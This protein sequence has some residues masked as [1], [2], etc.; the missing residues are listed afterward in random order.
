LGCAVGCFV[1]SVGIE[2]DADVLVG[3]ALLVVDQGLQVLVVGSG[4]GTG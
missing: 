4:G 2:S 1:G 3:P